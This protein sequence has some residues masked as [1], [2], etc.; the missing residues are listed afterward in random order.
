MKACENPQKCSELLFERER[1]M[2]RG[3]YQGMEGRIVMDK[4]VLC[5]KERNHAVY[6]NVNVKNNLL[7][8]LTGC[9]FRTF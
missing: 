9:V 4:K 2:G 6:I 5:K 7:E 3:R 1:E 8:V